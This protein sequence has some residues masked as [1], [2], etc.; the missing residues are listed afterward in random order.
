MRLQYYYPDALIVSISSH[1][2]GRYI[3]KENVIKYAALMTEICNHYGVARLDLRGSKVKVSDLPDGIHPNAAGMDYITDAVLEKLLNICDMEAGENVVYT[4]SHNLTDAQASL[5]YY[6]G[7]SSGKSFAETLTGLNPTVTVTMGGV[8]ITESCYSN[9][10]IFIEEVTGDLVITAADC[11]YG[12]YFQQLPEGASASTNLWAVLEHDSVYYTAN[13]W[14][15]YPSGTAYSV[16]VPIRGGDR[17]WAT[18]FGAA[19]ENGF[20][21]NGVRLTW[22]DENGVLQSMTRDEVYAQF[23]EFGCLIA[24]EGAVAVNVVMSSESNENEFYILTL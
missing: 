6:K 12:K 13:G 3:T 17:I 15:N 11:V 16:T 4:V 8:D 18:S 23:C 9:G 2:T 24:P 5:G 20:T 21:K 7:V 19:G 14:G 22:F 1:Y 10:K